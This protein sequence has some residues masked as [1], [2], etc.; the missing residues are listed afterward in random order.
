MKGSLGDIEHYRENYLPD[1]S[2]TG[3]GDPEAMHEGQACTC[4]MT[5]LPIVVWW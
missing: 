5:S 1:D 4:V 2:G 3:S